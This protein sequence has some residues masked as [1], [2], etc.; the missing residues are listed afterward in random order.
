MIGFIQ[1][2]G[3]QSGSDHHRNWFIKFM[4]FFLK[5][6][7]KNIPIYKKQKPLTCVRGFC[8]Y[9]VVAL[10]LFQEFKELI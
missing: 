1:Y 7:Y 2:Q 3:S 4:M 10:F 6:L 5:M 8:N 9:F